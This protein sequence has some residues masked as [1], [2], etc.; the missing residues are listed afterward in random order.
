MNLLETVEL[1]HRFPNTEDGI[2][3]I[4]LS[5][6][7]GEFI[8]LAGKNGSGKTVLAKHFNGLLE[9]TGG[10]VRYRG[11]PVCEQKLLVR[12]NIGFV[13]Q[14]AVHQFIGQTVREDIA[15]GP[16]NLGL[17][18][19]EIDRRVD[20]V[21]QMTGLVGSAEKQPYYLSG[22]EQKRCAIAGVLAMEPEVLILDEPFAGLDFPGVQEI[23]R[24]MLSIHSRG[25]TLIIITHD[26]EK[27][28]A[29]AERVLVLEAGRVVLDG[30]PARVA[31]SIEQ[32]GVR[33]PARTPKGIASMSWMEKPE[34]H[35]DE[36][37]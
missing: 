10:T 17:S 20:T 33:C 27:I 11:V 12:R 23:L 34:S 16:E 6:N 26:I 15:F 35:N 9:P 2:Q 19:A 32:Y 1:C 31:E 18:P 8:V 7:A 5:I 36:G 24:F 21:L 37:K 3:N 22:G 29:H 14:N 30:T 13:F 25:H 28:L 4:T